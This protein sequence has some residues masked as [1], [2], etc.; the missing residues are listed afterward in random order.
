MRVPAA[1]P[2]LQQLVAR[3]VEISQPDRF[4]FRRR[5]RAQVC[6]GRFTFWFR[7]N[8]QSSLNATRSRAT[9][10]SLPAFAVH[11]IEQMDCS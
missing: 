11:T 8:G 10:R 2:A 4:L 5:W 6:G 9:V 3:F 1:A 7:R